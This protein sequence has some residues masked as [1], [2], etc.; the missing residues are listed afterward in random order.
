MYVKTSAK[1][2]AA[3]LNTSSLLCWIHLFIL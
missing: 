2:G 3:M 1:E